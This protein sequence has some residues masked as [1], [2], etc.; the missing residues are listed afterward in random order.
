VQSSRLDVR[1]ELDLAGE[2]DSFIFLTLP[3]P[4]KGWRYD[5][6]GFTAA[7]QAQLREAAATG[8]PQGVRKPA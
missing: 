6:D 3:T 7:T 5:L 8:Q 2:P 1:T 4:N